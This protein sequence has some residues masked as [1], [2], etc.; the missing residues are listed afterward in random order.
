A[1]LVTSGPSPDA[2]RRPLPEGEASNSPTLMSMAATNAGVIIGAAAYMS[3]EQAR[4]RNADHPSDVFWIGCILYEM[5]AGRVAFDGE[6]VSDVLAAV[7]RSEPDFAAL[8]AHLS[9]QVRELLRRCLEKNP[10]RRWQ[11]AGDLRIEIENV[12]AR[13][14]AEKI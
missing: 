5:L 1:K 10:K 14:A 2:S 4:G 9:P 3:P 12:Q 13:P 11:A 8:P 6:D 7:L